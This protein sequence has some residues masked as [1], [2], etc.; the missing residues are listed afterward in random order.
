M[1]RCYPAAAAGGSPARLCP[2]RDGSE[3]GYAIAEMKY[4]SGSTCRR[5]PSCSK[6][7]ASGLDQGQ[8]R[9]A[10]L[11]DRP[12]SGIIVESLSVHSLRPRPRKKRLGKQDL[13]RPPKPVQDAGAMP[14]GSDLG[15]LVFPACRVRS[16]AKPSA[17]AIG[18]D[19]NSRQPL[20]AAFERFLPRTYK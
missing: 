4:A 2:A 8:P 18:H 19:F 12:R 20:R 15:P 16:A 17:V 11:L 5:L 3:P 6:P 1:P 9:P 7:R 14:E 13:K 10:S